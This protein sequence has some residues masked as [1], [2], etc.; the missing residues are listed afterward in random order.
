MPGLAFAVV[1]IQA[2]LVRFVT[3][4][5]PVTAG[6]LIFLLLSLI[7]FNEITWRLPPVGSIK[8]AA[9]GWAGSRDNHTLIRT[10]FPRYLAEAAAAGARLVVSPEAQFAVENRAL[11]LQQ[12]ALFATG[13]NLTL[14]VGYFN[15]A[16]NDNRIAF[17]SPEGE[18][19]AEYAK[20]H[21]VP[22]FENY[23]AGKGRRAKV[24]LE[25]WDLGGV[26]CQDDN[27]T[28]IT[29]AYGRDQVHLLVVPTHDWHAVKDFHLENTRLRTIEN[30]FALVRAASHGVSAIISSR[31][32]ILRQ[33]DH[34][35]GG[36]GLITAEV[37]LRT[38]ITLYA[39]LGDW[40][41][42][43]SALALTAWIL[44]AH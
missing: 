37:P 7:F 4:R 34:Y 9:M 17:I 13:H 11:W 10:E 42:P 18:I 41:I 38:G 1:A 30:G 12:M 23:T 24:S 36:D 29:R 31:G 33:L 5:E 6:L 25:E 26:I 14:A 35:R 15:M 44:L 27:F 21:L 28:D 43:L 40:L 2:L 22:F 3:H 39:R 8:V 32:E 16:G 20:T 19:R